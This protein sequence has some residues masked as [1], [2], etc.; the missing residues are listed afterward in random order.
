M[1]R[2]DNYNIISLVKIIG[3]KQLSVKEMM[4]GLISQLTPSPKAEIS[5]DCEGDGSV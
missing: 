3:G 1:L 5:A 2:T 4:T